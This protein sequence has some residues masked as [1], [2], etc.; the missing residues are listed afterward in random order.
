MDRNSE[1]HSIQG[2]LWKQKKGVGGSTWKKHWVYA[3]NDHFLQWSGKTRPAR[4]ETPK[5]AFKLAS[6]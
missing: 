1:V 4:N 5:Y 2:L 3:D 6:I